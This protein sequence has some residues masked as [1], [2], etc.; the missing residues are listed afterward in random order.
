M[1]RQGPGGVSLHCSAENRKKWENQQMENWKKRNQNV[2][3]ALSSRRPGFGRCSPHRTQ[4]FFGIGQ[5]SAFPNQQGKARTCAAF[6]VVLGSILWTFALLLRLSDGY[7]ELKG[8]SHVRLQI[9]LVQDIAPWRLQLVW[10]F[11]V[12]VS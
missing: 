11:W 8:R 6:D 4:F 2:C 3:H 5:L 7:L 1:H 10:V 9:P 12:F